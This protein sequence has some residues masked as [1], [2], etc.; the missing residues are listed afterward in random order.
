MK[1]PKEEVIPPPGGSLV[2]C[3]RDFLAVQW[4]RRHVP[5]Q[6]QG[7]E[8]GSIPGQGTKVPHAL[9]YRQKR[10]K[11]KFE[12]EKKPWLSLQTSLWTA[13]LPAHNHVSRFLKINRSP[14]THVSYSFHVSGEL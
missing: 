7:A 2:P 13:A 9:W 14:N 10:N 4:L 8:T 1:F 6:G 5:R 11:Y 3:L 12:K